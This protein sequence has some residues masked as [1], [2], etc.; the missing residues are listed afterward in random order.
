MSEILLHN[1]DEIDIALYK[2]F[3]ENLGREIKDQNEL[4]LGN[5]IGL[6]A[7]DLIYICLEIERIFNICIND[8]VIEKYQF[9]S[10]SSIKQF[11][12]DM[13]SNSKE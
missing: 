6:D 11:I 12:I 3:K 5:K 2:I 9:T 7:R 8:E 10:F 1:L 13:E 4:L